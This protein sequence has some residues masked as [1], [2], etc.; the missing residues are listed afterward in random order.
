M[1][2]IIA[3]G[4]I[5]EQY[6]KDMINDYKERINKYHKLEI[7]ELKDTN[8]LSEE[9]NLIKNHI[10]NNDFIITLEIEGK[11]LDSLDF[12]K[13]NDKTFINYSNIVFIIGSSNGIDQSIK[14]ISNYHLS[15]SK[16]TYPHGL[17]R[18]ILLEQIYR[19]YKINNNETY[20]K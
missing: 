20:H 9:A 18:A 15:F 3:L 11:M 8:N 17:F 19:A 1:I 16:L 7:I 13:L 14:E 2:K 12:A 4:K 10:S 6:L 5:K